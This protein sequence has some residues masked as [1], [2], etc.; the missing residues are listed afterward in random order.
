[1]ALPPKDH[2][3]S[4]D[5]RR[6]G[7]PV[8]YP[9]RYADDFILLVGAPPGPNQ[10]ERAEEIARKEKADL[11][12]YLKERLGLEL[13]E[14]KTLVTSVTKP[15]LFLG[16]HVRVRHHPVHGGLVSTAVIPRERSQRFRRR[17]KEHFRY[18]TVGRSLRDQIR[19]LNPALRGWSNFYRH[20]WGAKK[21]LSGIDHYVWWTIYR[22]LKKKQ[23]EGQ[24]IRQDGPESHL[25]TKQG[26]PTMGGVLILLALALSTL[27]WADL[28]N[29]Y[30]WVVLFVT[31]GFG[32]IGFFDD[33]LK[34]TRRSS[35]GLPSRT[36]FLA[37]LLVGLL[38]SIAIAYLTRSEIATAIALPFVKN[39]LLELTVWGFVPWSVFVMTAWSN[40]VNLTDGLDGLAIVPTMFAAGCFAFI[41]YVVGNTVFSEYLQL[42]YVEGTGEL[43]VFCGA[44]IGAGLGF[45]W[46]NAPPAMVFMGDTG[47]LSVGGALGAMSVITKHELVLV[48]I[49]GLFVLET[50]SVI[51][52]VASFKMTGKRVFRMAPLHHHFEK[53]GWAEPTI[54]IRFWIIAAIL[55]LAGLATLKLR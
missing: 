14:E 2:K 23:R 9:I 25:I 53:K 54:V 1:M 48:I 21:V 33:F 24:P 42:H 52:Q 50:V 41:A 46:F 22:W 31:V 16:H 45:L 49:G 34:L 32:L 4:D 40:A 10:D 5:D 8:V 20:A 55:A 12:V 29:Y 13:S 26:T 11:A 35:R 38:A 30:V 7:R 6:R 47:S 19:E 39:L 27:L 17:V 37:Q 15:M 36:K 51:V 44:L 3:D 18:P 43:A 28:G